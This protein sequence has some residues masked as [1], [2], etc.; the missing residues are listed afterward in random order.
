M[1]KGFRQMLEDAYE[2]DASDFA[3]EATDDRVSA[4]APHQLLQLC[5]CTCS[6]FRCDFRR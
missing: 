1:I 5:L 2:G 3:K 4:R 6:C